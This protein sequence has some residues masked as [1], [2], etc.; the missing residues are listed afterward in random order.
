MYSV[1]STEQRDGGGGGRGGTGEIGGG[2]GGSSVAI[3]LQAAGPLKQVG[4][5]ISTRPVRVLPLRG[6]D[7]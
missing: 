1:C 6:S 2:G 7:L 3:L 5:R 4:D